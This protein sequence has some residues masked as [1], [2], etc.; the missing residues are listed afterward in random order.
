MHEIEY[1]QKLLWVSGPCQM[2]GGFPACIFEVTMSFDRMVARF[3][4]SLRPSDVLLTGL[5]PYL[6][7]LLSVFGSLQL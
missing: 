4:Q 3:W 2:E 1:T 6:R 7:A 5:G